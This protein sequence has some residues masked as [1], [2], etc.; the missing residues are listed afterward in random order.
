MVLYVEQSLGISATSCS[1]ECLMLRS[2]TSA[3]QSQALPMS[4]CLG[5]L[6]LALQD[7]FLQRT[8]SRQALLTPVSVQAAMDEVRMLSNTSEPSRGLHW[9]QRTL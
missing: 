5:Q 4:F 9:V 7:S 8:S 6:Q 2:A 1:A 3:A